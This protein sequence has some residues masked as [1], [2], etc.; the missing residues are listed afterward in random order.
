MVRPSLTAM[1]IA[2]LLLS[3]TAFADK[4]KSQDFYLR[5]E[6][7]FSFPS[8][9]KSDGEIAINEGIDVPYYNNKAPKGSI[10][11]GAALGYRFNDN[12]RTDFNI[13]GRNYSFNAP[14][15]VKLAGDLSSKINA[16]QKISAVMMMLN[17]YY[18][19]GQ[20]G[21]VTPYITA[22][23]GASFNKTGDYKFKHDIT[24]PDQ[25]QI[26]SEVLM[27]GKSNVSLAWNVGAGISIACSTNASIDESFH[28]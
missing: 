19:I 28:N 14:L 4:N 12:F 10:I 1:S 16:S 26:V 27:K 23:I 21:I 24:Q 25:L 5:I 18:D 2:V 13:S 22:G 11:Y 9:L 17:G 7:G 20:Y 3:S 15:D 6:S 8:S